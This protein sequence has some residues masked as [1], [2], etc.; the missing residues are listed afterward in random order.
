M[1]WTVSLHIEASQRASCVKGHLFL[2]LPPK[3]G[4]SE[5]RQTKQERATLKSRPCQKHQGKMD[6]CGGKCRQ[7]RIGE[8]MQRLL[9]GVIQ[10]IYKGSR[11]HPLLWEIDVLFL[12]K[13][14]STHL[15]SGEPRNQ[16]QGCISI[17]FKP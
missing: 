11:Q 8:Q 10:L 4:H 5:L 12:P 3:C 2:G 14:G 16:L 13:L 1:T 7:E 17:V 6:F 9:N 15:F